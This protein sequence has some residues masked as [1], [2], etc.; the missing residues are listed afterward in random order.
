MC[1]A[2]EIAQ[3]DVFLPNAL[4]I[5]DTREDSKQVQISTE[6]FSTPTFQL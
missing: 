3:P 6:A 4:D 2:F 1:T 5:P